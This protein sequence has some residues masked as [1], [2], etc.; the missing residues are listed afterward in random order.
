V[1]ISTPEMR[2]AAWKYGHKS[3]IILDGTFGL[4]DHRILCFILMGID[5]A[6]KGVPLAFLLFSA[7]SGNKH[8]AGGYDHT[9]LVDLLREWKSDLERYAGGETFIPLVAITDTDLKECLA[10]QIVFKGIW[11]LLCKFHIRQSWRNH[12]N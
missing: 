2:A 6:R 11:L 12:R 1:C 9:I 5:E 4:C 3:Q 7:P 8:T 10:L